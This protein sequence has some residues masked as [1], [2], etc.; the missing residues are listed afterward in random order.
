MLEALLP[1]KEVVPQAYALLYDR[2]ATA[3][4][5]LQRYGTQGRCVGEA[6]WEPLPVED[7][8]HLDERRAKVGLGPEADYKKLFPYCT[9]ELAKLMAG[10]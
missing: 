10:S 2:V 1:S 7:P 3:D 9:A 5:R 6:T 4:K 8:D